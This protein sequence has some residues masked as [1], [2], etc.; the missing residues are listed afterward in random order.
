MSN[1]SRQPSSGWLSDHPLA[2]EYDWDANHPLTPDRLAQLS[3]R[4]V[5]WRCS[6]NR[7]HTWEATPNNRIGRRSGCPDCRGTRVSDA[8]RLSL[9]C[10]DES[11][12]GQWDVEKNAPL[13]PADVSI[14]SNRKVAWVCP[15]ATDHQWTASVG[16]RVSGRGCPF[17]AGHRVSSTNRLSTLRPDIASQLDAERS[18]ISADDLSVGSN[19]IVWW[20]CPSDP[21]HAPWLA[22]VL[23][24]TGGHKGGG[25]G[26]PS[27]HLVHTSAQELR[28][29]AELSQ[30]LPIDPRRSHVPN[31]KGRLEKV[32][33]VAED[34]ACG[35]RLVLEFDGLW[36]HKS[37]SSPKRD[38]DKARRLQQAGWTVVRIR[39][40]GLPE[41]HGTPV[42]VVE[43]NAEPEDAAEMVL[44]HLSQLGI[45][46]SDE[47]DGYLS[48]DPPCASELA[49][50]WIFNQLG[51]RALGEDRRG[52]EDAWERMYLAL[53]AFE[54]DSGHCRVPA[55]MLVEGVSLERWVY[56]QR[57]KSRQGKLSL[58]R[59]KRLEE[60]PSWSFD[61]VHEADF[62]NGYDRYMAWLERRSY[63]GHTIDGSRESRAATI[64]ASNL[65]IRRRKLQA[66]G[67]DLPDA[68]ISAMAA[69][70][71]WSWAP[72]TDTFNA[73]ISLLQEYLSEHQWSIADIRQRDQWGEHRIGA[74]INAWRTRRD[75]LT[76]E[77][78]L[79][80]EA[81]PG[82]TWNRHS[83]AWE[84]NFASLAAFAAE[85]GHIRPRLDAANDEERVLA[86][87]KRNNKSRLSGQ[88]NERAQ[89]LR[90]FLAEYDEELP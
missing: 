33:M 1:F 24:R 19:H 4:K 34:V 17:C 8:N 26:C 49:E 51:E 14:G 65:R 75:Q 5:W 12:L 22:P 53:R 48:A 21:G 90:K 20:N 6:R 50:Q 45:V 74:W 76:P 61:S 84:T 54:S 73:K 79:G 59:A 40:E 11:L 88:T 82:W 25:A 78:Q 68:H 3:N 83:D 47:V 16:Q 72:S 23:R 9:N 13:T 81:I 71:G 62:R 55:D 52:H 36:W 29:K 86:R 31:T 85:H 87:W 67:E 63:P 39:E 27:C 77:Q 7:E 69:I 70:P 10:P 57:H 41:L 2:A 89:R 37:G 64:W 42:V 56:K 44:H 66:R 80:L 28:L 46:T 35:L 60:I 32:D 18:G 15:Q 58:A 43:V 38:A 30:V